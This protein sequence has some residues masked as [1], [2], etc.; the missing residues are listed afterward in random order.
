[1]KAVIYTRV[2]TTEQAKLGYS[3]KD[4]E[5]KCLDFAQKK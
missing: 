5:E 4:Q 3:L 2:S 1:M